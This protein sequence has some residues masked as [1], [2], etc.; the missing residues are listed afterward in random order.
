MDYV[1]LL[2]C[3]LIGVLSS[4]SFGPI[5]I[6]TFNRG[7]VY[8]F[9]R[10]F[11]TALGACVVDGFYFFLGLIGVLAV[12]KES[13]NFLI[14]FDV[15]G[16]FMLIFFGIYALH[17]ITKSLPNVSIGGKLG[18]GSTIIKSFMLTIFNPLVL[19]FFMLLGAQVLPKGIQALTLRQTF[20]ASVMVMLGSLSIL[21]FVSL[22]A[23]LL[24]KCMSDFQL[25]VI[26][27][28][29]GVAFIGIGTYLIIFAP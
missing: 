27:F 23:S 11:A 17:K 10:G 6:L 26:Y 16:G 3:F 20:A 15:I 22:V 21:S 2:R 28:V 8:G 18:I 14:L 5:F 7:A 4:S 29:T 13:R 12:I 24:G 25:K 19:L 1:I 9:L